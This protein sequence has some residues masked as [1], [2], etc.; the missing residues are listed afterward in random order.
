MISGLSHS[1]MALGDHTHLELARGAAAFIR[2]TL[3]K[4]DTGL[5]IRNAYRDKE[6]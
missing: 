5:L 4:E 6:G 3:Y 1:S 2:R